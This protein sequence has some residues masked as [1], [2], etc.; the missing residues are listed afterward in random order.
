MKFCYDLCIGQNAALIRDT[1]RTNLFCCLVNLA[2]LM[3]LGINYKAL[4]IY[5]IN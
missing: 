4:A 5:L 1:W 3:G 2:N